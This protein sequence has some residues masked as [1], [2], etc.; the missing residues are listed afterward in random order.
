MVLVVLIVAA[1]LFLLIDLLV[2]RIIQ[3]AREKRLRRERA[4]ALRVHLDLDF[5]H[6]AKTLKRVEVDKPRARILAVDDEGVILDSFRKILVVDGYSVDTVESG[7]EALGL[8]QKHHYDF[9]FT[10][11]KM[12]EMDGIEVCKS[13]KHMRPDI[14][15]VIITGYGTIESAVETMKHGAM[16]YV[17]KPFTEDELLA[18]TKK[19]LIRRQDRVGKLLKPQVHITH[20]RNARLPS[21][22]EFSIPGGV[23]ISESHCWASV[24]PDGKVYVGIDDFAK[25]IIGTVDDIELPN[26][27]MEVARGQHLFSVI[28]GTN[29]IP[30]YSPISGK[31]EGLN[32]ALLDNLEELDT[33]TYYDSWLCRLDGAKLHEELKKLKIGQGAVAFFNED[34]ERLQDY[35]V[36]HVKATKDEAKVPADGQLYLGELA[37]LKE[38]DFNAILGDLFRRPE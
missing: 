19:L 5:S 36:R 32:K 1:V 29:S 13:V 26:L 17:Q 18:M 38:K 10:D 23:F 35:V 21:A 16:D 15:V 8:I 31:V 24:N 12:P 9:V 37:Q 34:I 7:R 20:L 11:L 33:T 27:G 22:V 14:D 4:E 28:Q 30:F 3:R 6:E 25:K 2:R